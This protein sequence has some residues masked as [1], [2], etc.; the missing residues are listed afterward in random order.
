MTRQF[1]EKA[2]GTLPKVN[3][4]QFYRVRAEGE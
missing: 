1:R 2:A 4:F 3:T